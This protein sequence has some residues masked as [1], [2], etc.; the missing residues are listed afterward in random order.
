MKAS[1]PA[2]VVLTTLPEG[3]PGTPAVSP[4]RH[5]IRESAREHVAGMAD[6]ARQ[7]DLESVAPDQVGWAGHGRV[8]Q[9]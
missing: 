1:S 5:T 3:A 6:I 2:V 7:A 4:A 8:A 9:G